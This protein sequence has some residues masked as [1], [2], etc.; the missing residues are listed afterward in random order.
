MGKSAFLKEFG[1]VV[2]ERKIFTHGVIFIDKCSNL[3]ELKLQLSD[4]MKKPE[5]EELDQYL[6]N[7]NKKILIIIDNVNNFICNP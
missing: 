3:K 7:S 2:F 4:I 5:K 6:K 1:W